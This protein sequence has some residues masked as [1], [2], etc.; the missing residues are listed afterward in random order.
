MVVIE[1]AQDL[2]GEEVSVIV[3]RNLQSETGRM[4][5]AKVTE[6]RCNLDT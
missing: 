5:F 1:A 4:I 6:A 3:T 2:L